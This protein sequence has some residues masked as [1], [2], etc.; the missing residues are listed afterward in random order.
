MKDAEAVEVAEYAVREATR[1]D[2]PATKWRRAPRARSRLP[3]L[4]DDVAWVVQYGPESSG[5]TWCRQRMRRTSDLGL[6][7]S[8][9]GRSEQPQPLGSGQLRHAHL[10]YLD[11]GRFEHLLAVEHGVPP[12]EV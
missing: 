5:S 3:S 10:H 8:R 4:S 1:P 6:R 11:T 9:N 2:A 12:F 7:P